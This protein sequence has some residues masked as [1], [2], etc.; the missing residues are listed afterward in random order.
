MRH[1]RS[2]ALACVAGLAVLAPVASHA[3]SARVRGT[4]LQS[5][6]LQDYVNVTVYPSSIVR[7][8]NLVYGDFG[9]KDVDGGDLPD[10]Q[11]NNQNSALDNAGRM[12][13]AHVSGAGSVWGLQLNE[14]HIPLSSAYGAD[15]YNRNPNE[16][17]ALLW[18]HKFGGITAGAMYT[19]SHSSFEQGTTEIQ[20]FPYTGPGGALVGDNA[21]Q[22]M[23]N[24][25]AGL[26]SEPRN[27]D[28]L[29]GGVSFDWNMSGRRHTADVSVQYRTLNLHQEAVVA[30]DTQ[31]LNDD[32]G[33]GIAFNGRA[34]IA[35]SDDSYLVPVVNYY[36]MSLGTE[37]TDTATPGVTTTVDND[38]T[39]INIGLAK[40]WVM[41]E[42]DLLMLGL[43]YEHESISFGDPAANDEVTYTQCPSLFGALEVRPANWLQLRF[44]AGSPL[45]NNLTITDGTTGVETKLSDSEFQ[46]ALGLGF[47][48]GGRLDLDAVVNQDFA[49]TGGWAASGTSE[50][51][52][53]R[54]SATYRF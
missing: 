43:A 18:G 45:F 53:S 36:H 26:G 22:I 5:D 21:R 38:V 44:G 13:G 9:V 17:I 2:I 16:A 20:P 31:E 15:Y 49:F 51:P 3:S 54:I 10:F 46:Y 27:T 30:G 1:I 25:N 47:R 4:G 39:G 7:Y 37:F 35:T 29:L 52:F 11:D 32:G 23:N 50:T 28:G 6:Y 41:R 48:I 24:I 14:N 34:Q 33:A 19:R 8:S 12:M 40:G 42:S